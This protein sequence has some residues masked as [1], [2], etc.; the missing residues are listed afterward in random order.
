MSGQPVGDPKVD[1]AQAALSSAADAVAKAADTTANVAGVADEL[2]P[3]R[4]AVADVGDAAESVGRAAGSV[5]DA[6]P[7]LSGVTDRVTAVAGGIHAATDAADAVGEAVDNMP[8]LTP[9][10]RRQREALLAAQLAELRASRT[11]FY[12]EAEELEARGRAALDVRSSLTRQPLQIAG[13]AA[14][15]GFVLLGGPGRVWKYVRRRVVPRSIRPPVPPALDGVLKAMGDDGTAA[16]EL[17]DMIAASRAR[18]RPGRIQRLLS[19]S[20]FLP[21]GLDLGRRLTTRLLDVDPVVKERELAKI[22][23]RNDARIA[24]AEAAKAAAARPTP[25]APGGANAGPAPA[26]PAE[27][28]PR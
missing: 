25:A 16:Q 2:M 24:E 17:A 3:V 18:S 12:G 15:T 21:L 13:L 5:G 11:A 19:G 23:A 1:A 27:E 10:L 20:V 9:E 6:V 4:A 28:P 26:G 8:R 7:A 14:G 22:R